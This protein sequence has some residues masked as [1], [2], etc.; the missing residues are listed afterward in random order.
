MSLI[1]FIP[2]DPKK[3]LPPK[4]WVDPQ[5]KTTQHS[6]SKTVFAMSDN[7]PVLVY[8]DYE[9]KGWYGSQRDNWT[10]IVYWLKEEIL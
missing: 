4:T 6:T 1:R 7:G 5:Y 3:E 2:T 9:T 10:D 8:Y